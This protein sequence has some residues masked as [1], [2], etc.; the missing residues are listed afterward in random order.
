MK[1]SNISSGVL[2]RGDGVA[3]SCCVRLLQ[4]LGLAVRFDTVPRAKLPAI[5]MGER[6][7]RLLQDVVGRGDLL[8]ALPR[9]SRR[10]VA[11]GQNAEPAE[12]PHSAVVVS[13]QVLLERLRD[14]KA[15][16]GQEPSEAAW[17]IHATRPFPATTMH[18][19]GWRLATA[20][21]VVLKS[22]SSDACWV[23]SLEHGWLFVLPGGDDAGWLLSVGGDPAELLS[24]SRLVAAQIEDGPAILGSFAA[25]PRI[26]EPLCGPGWLACG[27]EAIGFDPLY[28]DGTGYA[29]REAILGS[30][31]VRAVADGA[32]VETAIGHYRAR[33][34]GGLYRHLKLC[35]E[36]Y[37]AGGS[38]SWWQQ[39]VE[40]LV[41]GL[42]WCQQEL[43]NVD[44]FRYRLNGFRL[45]PVL[46]QVV[47][48]A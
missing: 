24:E 42:E 21:T 22:R 18:Q 26:A 41:E 28:G 40:G 36:F 7:S 35:R 39:Q 45:E 48:F 17:T 32:D 19:F 34:I 6:T 20:S 13:E 9:V 37:S 31:V 11:W 29:I 27:T 1:E 12:I 5:L 2:V 43:S 46:N 10:V 30:A 38:G 44:G 23:E 4:R 3:A 15:D 33:L 14:H 8:S 16:T 25:H 47:P